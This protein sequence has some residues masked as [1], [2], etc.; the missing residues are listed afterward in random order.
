MRVTLALV[1]QRLAQRPAQRVQEPGSIEAAVALILAPAGGGDLELLLIR[2][3][4]QAGDPWSGQM[5]LPGGRR[6][7]TDPDLLA[8]AARETKEEVGIELRR[9]WLI[10]E[11]DDLHPRTR[12]LPPVVVR[13]FVFGL[14]H[15]PPIGRSSEVAFHVWVSL[16]ELASGTTR[17]EILIPGRDRPF[18]AYRVGEQ[19]VWGM[20]ERIILSLID[21]LR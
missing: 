9:E 15:Q 7:P 2:R 17:T 10:G 4:E 3:A 13:P 14:E 12:T 5:A 16:E 21:L 19:I 8:T 1:R 6:D 18:P 20:T 11:L